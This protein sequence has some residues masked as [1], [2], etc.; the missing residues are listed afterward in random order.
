MRLLTSRYHDLFDEGLIGRELLDDLGR[1]PA[2]GLLGTEPPALDLGLRT[3]ELIRRF[4]MFAGLG[5]GELKALARLFRPRL[6]VPDERVIRRGER[7]TAM[8]FISSGAVEVVLPNQRVRLGSG[9]FFGEM[10]LLSGRRRRADVVALGFCRVLVLS[11]AD[12]RRFLSH[13]PAAK[14]EI[15]RVA[16]QR[17][18]ANEERALT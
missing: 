16:E 12:F 10:A 13:Y 15:D 11:A 5:E 17:A 6:L 1:E 8:F 14:A 18:R 2:A 4:D 7:G 9:D 3:E